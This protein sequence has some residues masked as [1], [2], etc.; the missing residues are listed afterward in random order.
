MITAQILEEWWKF[1][2]IGFHNPN[3]RSVAAWM[4]AVFAVA[5][6]IYA[7]TKTVRNVTREFRKQRRLKKL[8][9]ERDKKRREEAWVRWS[10]LDL[11][12]QK[13]L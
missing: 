10:R 7:I 9:E 12:T 1:I 6:L 8:L 3:T 11:K 2:H 13:R 5:I 4:L